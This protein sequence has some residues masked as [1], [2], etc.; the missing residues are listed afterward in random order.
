MQYAK[1][2]AERQRSLLPKAAG[3]VK[4]AWHAVTGQPESPTEAAIYKGAGGG[5]TASL[6]RTGKAALNLVSA[7]FSAIGETVQRGSESLGLGGIPF[8]PG[9]PKTGTVAELGA[10][11]TPTGLLRRGGKAASAVAEKVLR[12]GTKT[13][14]KSGAQGLEDE[15][16]S[17]MGETKTESVPATTTAPRSAEAV[18]PSEQTPVSPG[19]TPSQRLREQALASSR[20][21]RKVSSVAAASTVSK[22]P[23]EQL[24]FPFSEKMAR[25]GQMNLLDSNAYLLPLKDSQKT[26]A[27]AAERTLKA[28]M[29]ATSEDE[30]KQLL[31]VE[32]LPTR[33]EWGKHMRDYNQMRRRAG[34]KPLDVQAHT[35]AF[36]KV[37]AS[38][39]N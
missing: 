24:P 18:T 16:L 35:P 8:L 12:R 26:Q 27:Q 19:R 3:D 37:K 22:T 13:E 15:L 2:F 25:K 6:Y 32:R 39:Y 1:E 28:V 31:N 23:F 33:A 29:H 11:V 14:T 21:S 5:G 38:A 34:M 7:P 36:L 10:A 20:A 9:Q 17:S 30:A 4:S